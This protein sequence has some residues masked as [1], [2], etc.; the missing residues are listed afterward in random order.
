LSIFKGARRQEVVPVLKYGLY[1][2]V[3]SIIFSGAILWIQSLWY[4]G[5][6]GFAKAL[7]SINGLIIGYASIVFA[8]CQFGW[9]QIPAVAEAKAMHNYKLIDDYIKSSLHNG[10]NI[11]AF[12][13]VI[14]IGLSNHLLYLFHGDA[15]LIGHIPFV[16]LTIA[17]AILGIEFLICSLLIGLGE[18]RKAAYLISVL[19]LI[20]III[21]PILII[22]FNSYFGTE[23]TLFAGPVS[24]LTSSIIILPFAFHYLLKYTHNPPR[25]YRNILGKG[26]ISIIL[27]LLCY[28]ILEFTILTNINP[29]I[30]LIVRAAILLGFFM[31]FLLIFAGF[32]DV[33]LDFYEHN[34]GVLKVIVPGL[35]WLLHHSPFFEPE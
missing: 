8:I 7:V 25:I 23:S 17:V 31:L 15:Y 19:T 14:Y 30:G 22:T 20:Q 28:A 1:C 2:I 11:S 9:A 32:T 12:L 35:R 16:I 5:F 34:L 29:I 4:S 10:F 33:D 13:L 21:V 27:T 24:L 3:P 26:T 6:F 18:G